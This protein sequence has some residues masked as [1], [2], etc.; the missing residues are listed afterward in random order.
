M[1]LLGGNAVGPPLHCVWGKS[2][3]HLTSRDTLAPLRTAC[4]PILFRSAPQEYTGRE[5]QEASLCADTL[6]PLPAVSLGERSCWEPGGGH[7]DCFTKLAKYCLL[8]LAF[9]A[10]LIPQVVSRRDW[11]CAFKD[12]IPARGHTRI[13]FLKKSS[14]WSKWLSIALTIV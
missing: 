14:R 5:R 1:R 2:E 11:R 12:R 6:Q 13:F 3:S 4:Q 9:L 8:C 10:S 7:L